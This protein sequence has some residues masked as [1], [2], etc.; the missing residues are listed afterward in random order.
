MSTIENTKQELWEVQ[1]E[2]RRQDQLKREGRFRHTLAD[3]G[4]PD[5]LKL[6]AV[7]EEL[8]EVG[9]NLLARAGAVQDGDPSL[10]AIHTEVTQVAALSVA[11]MECLTRQLRARDRDPGES[12]LGSEQDGRDVEVVR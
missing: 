11:W 5:E 7:L 4:M 3:S 1:L 12:G 8:A 9:K 6:A 10:E 2:R